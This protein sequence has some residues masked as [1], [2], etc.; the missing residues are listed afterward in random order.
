MKLDRTDVEILRALQEDARLS[1]RQLARRVGVSVPTVSA[2]VANLEQIGV[3]TAY[4]AVVDANRLRQTRVVLLLRCVRGTED[5]VGAALSALNEVRWTIRTEGSRIIAEAFLSAPGLISQFVRKARGLPGVRSV[6]HHV[7]QKGFK[8]APRAL[9]SEGLIAILQC[10]E[11]GRVIEGDPVRWKMDG[12]THYLCCT[13]CEKLYK[14]R[15][16]RLKAGATKGSMGRLPPTV[17]GGRLPEH[18]RRGI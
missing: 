5:S 18:P 16:L 17:P 2:R 9:V 8:D 7:A 3:L 10:F 14:D 12:R 6:E 11:C 4:R 13:S 15:Y 1:Y